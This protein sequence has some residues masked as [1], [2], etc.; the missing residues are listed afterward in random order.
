MPTMQD[1]ANL[2]GVSLS[3]VSRVL[4]KSE[5][6]VVDKRM[7]VERAIEQLGFTPSYFARSL[8]TK[9]SGLVG[10][11]VPDISYAY[12]SLM[13]S[14]IE[15]YA[16]SRDQNILICNIEEKLGKELR[17]LSMFAEMRVEGIVLM[18][19]KSNQAVEGFLLGCGIPI[20]LASV[21][22][23]ALAGKFPSV[24]IDDFKAAYDATEFLVK[25]GRKRIA[26]IA[27]DLADFT[28]GES[29]FGGYRAALR[30][31]GL[32]YD[33]SI[34]R[35]GSFSI[36]EGFTMTSSIIES[37]V[38]LPDAVFAAADVLAVGVLRRLSLAGLS[39]PSDVAVMG[40]DDLEYSTICTP[41]LSTVHQPVRELGIAAME[42]LF[43]QIDAPNSNVRE[44]VLSHELVV[45][46]ST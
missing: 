31:Y 23:K 8:V 27:G 35:F 9:K 38:S 36:D 44:V 41:R 30:D 7:R 33:E 22:P 4:N 26:F 28:S 12:Y 1:V 43:K 19:E 14:G 5:S 37:G 34:V 6:V 10:V 11:I 24:N 46:E 18:H 16:S 25:K 21:R 2:A 17:Y 40:F 29:R 39:V 42:L 20:V 15:S 32:V 13:L 3:T 45:R